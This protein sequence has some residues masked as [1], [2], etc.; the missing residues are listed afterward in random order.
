MLVLAISR[1]GWFTDLYQGV[2]LQNKISVEVCLLNQGGE[3]L[4][5]VM[6][7]EM[8]FTYDRYPSYKVI[9]AAP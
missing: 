3:R 9:Q 6:Y 2:P 5:D 1:G 7:F 4:A 8:R